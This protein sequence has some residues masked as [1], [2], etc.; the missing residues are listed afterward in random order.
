MRLRGSIGRA[1][2]LAGLMAISLAIA[3]CSGQAPQ[4]EQYALAT[5]PAPGGVEDF[6]ASAG[7]IVHFAGD[8]AALS[9]EAKSILRRQI[10]WLNAHPQYQVT[11]EGHA[12]EW[13]TR[14]H[15]L[16]LGAQRATVVK[17]F[18]KRNG[19]RTGRIHTVSYGKE[20]LIEDCSA[21]SCRSK[22]RR[23]QT[24]VRARTAGRN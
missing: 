3:A 16:E 7:D 24:V 20:R 6:A 5:A 18:L 13:G 9:G 23:A 15:N 19:L 8:S 12:D 1:C 11:I 14:A 2:G 21:I 22:N 17:A 4:P 10:R